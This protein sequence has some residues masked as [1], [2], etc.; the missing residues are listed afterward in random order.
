MIAD[1]LENLKNYVKL[2]DGFKDVLDFI[3]KTD[4]YSLPLGKMP[5]SDRVYL[6]RQQYVGKEDDNSSFEHHYDYIDIQIV[7]ENAEKIYYST[8]EAGEYE[9]NEKDVYH[10]DADKDTAVI[11]KE[12]EF[13][14]FF[15]GELHKCVKY[16]DEKIE[17]I[18]FKVKK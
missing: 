3:S 17:K 14:I 5:V 6:N 4:L 2:N 15:V 13:A 1:K 7:L 16:N 12:N 10:T 18:I 9:I 11:V 8:K